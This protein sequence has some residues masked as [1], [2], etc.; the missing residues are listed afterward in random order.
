M[1]I[2][3]PE[4]ATYFPELADRWGIT[5]GYD[6]ASE[7]AHIDAQPVVDVAPGSVKSYDV[8]LYEMNVMLGIQQPV[9]VQYSNPYL[10]SHERASLEAH[11]YA[12]RL[13]ANLLQIV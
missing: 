2:V 12:Q 5:S 4:V 11:V 13:A 8:A 9:V 6:P 1:A 10:P 7:S 3:S